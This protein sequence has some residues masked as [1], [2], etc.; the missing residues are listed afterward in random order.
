MQ[1]KIERYTLSTSPMVQAFVDIQWDGWLQIIGLNYC[2]DNTLRSAQLTAWRDGRR[3]FWNAIEIPDPD[4]RELVTQEIL[5][6]IR[7]HVATLPPEERV[8]PPRPPRPPQHP[9]RP[10]VPPATR[11]PLRQARPITQPNGKH[12]VPPPLRLAVD[13]RPLFRAGGDRRGK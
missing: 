7:A 12:P 9:A 8:K 5:A 11:P 13:K 6:A 4:L 2:R 1:I 3:L 10:P